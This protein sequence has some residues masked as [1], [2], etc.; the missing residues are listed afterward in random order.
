ME[1]QRERHAVELGFELILNVRGTDENT[2]EIA[3]CAA[4]LASPDTLDDHS[5][6]GSHC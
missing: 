4:T 6:K 5:A 1:V 2:A 3:R